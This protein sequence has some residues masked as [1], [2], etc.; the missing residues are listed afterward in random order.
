M[1]DTERKDRECS[2]ARAAAAIIDA[3]T[4]T[5]YRDREHRRSLAAAGRAIETARRIIYGTR[6]RRL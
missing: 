6:H 2:L 3:T 5:P 4:V 1:T